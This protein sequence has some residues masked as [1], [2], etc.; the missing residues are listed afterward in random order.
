[1]CIA[2]CMPFDIEVL[3]FTQWHL[4]YKRVFVNMN[5]FLQICRELSRRAM[6]ARIKKRIR[7]LWLWDYKIVMASF[8]VTT[9]YRVLQE[10]DC[11]WDQSQEDAT[12]SKKVVFRGKIWGMRVLRNEDAMCEHMN[13]VSVYITK[14]KWQWRTKEMDLRAHGAEPTWA[15]WAWKY[16]NV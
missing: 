5:N 15:R 12:F 2:L 1:M 9:Q 4:E 10:W 6:W 14:C 3:S 16:L 8:I 7:T 13:C 11:L